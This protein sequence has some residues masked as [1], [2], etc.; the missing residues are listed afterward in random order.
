MFAFVAHANMT[1][2]AS[3]SL[4]HADRLGSAHMPPTRLRSLGEYLRGEHG[5]LSANTGEHYIFH[6]TTLQIMVLQKP[7]NVS[8]ALFDQ[9]ATAVRFEADESQSDNGT[10]DAR[11]PIASMQIGTLARWL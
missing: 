11:L 3:A 5:T 7:A 2:H 8:L 10:R 9:N 4:R 1:R 6:W